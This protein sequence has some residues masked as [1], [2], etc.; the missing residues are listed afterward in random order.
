MANNV[1][2]GNAAANAEASAVVALLNSGKLR[3]Y[4]GT[5]PA[6]ADTAI[7]TQTLLCELTFGS[8]AGGSPSN[9]VITFNAITSDSSANNGGTPSWFRA[10]K[11]DG[12]TSVF[13]GTVGTGA[14]Y[15]CIIDA[16][17]IVQG[18]TVACTSMTY[19][20]YKG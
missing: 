17:P 12:T 8:T 18:A 11:S 1:H 19:T 20:A 14:G 15:D 10:L 4:N 7:T 2:L 5:Q 3:V 6:T 16:S 13:D 9:G